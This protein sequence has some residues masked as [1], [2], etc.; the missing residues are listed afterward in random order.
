MESEPN[1]ILVKKK[2]LISPMVLRRLNRERKPVKRL[3]NE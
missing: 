1:P 3:I 2:T